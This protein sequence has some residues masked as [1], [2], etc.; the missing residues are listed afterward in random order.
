[1]V[2]VP[3]T[4]QRTQVRARDR[5]VVGSLRPKSSHLR[6]FHRDAFAERSLGYLTIWPTGEDQPAVSTMNSLDG[7]I[8]ANAAIVPAGYEG[9]VSV[10]VSN[11]T[12]VVLDIDGYFAPANGSTLRIIRSLPV[13]YWT[14]ATLTEI[15]V[16]PTC[17]VG[18]SAISQ[19]SKAVAF[20]RVLPRKPIR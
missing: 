14:R 9:T 11:L 13:V 20:R 16:G 2:P 5:Q 15:W 7:R 3:G 8:K 10:Y 17:R 19:C 1:M 12:N 6:A 4:V 18:R